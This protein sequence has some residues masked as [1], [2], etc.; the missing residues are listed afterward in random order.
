M[1]ARFRLPIAQ[2]AESIQEVDLF[3]ESGNFPWKYATAIITHKA[4]KTA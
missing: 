3:I 4:A 2:A 1:L